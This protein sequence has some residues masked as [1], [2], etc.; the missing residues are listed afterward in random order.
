VRN[1]H[2]T[3]QLISKERE[4]GLFRRPAENF[5]RILFPPFEDVFCN[6][7]ESLKKCH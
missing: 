1:F 7:K 6:I 3:V 4:I 5:E 2:P